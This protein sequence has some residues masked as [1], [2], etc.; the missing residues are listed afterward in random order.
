MA[1]FFPYAV[2]ARLAPFWLPFGVLVLT[3]LGTLRQDQAGTAPP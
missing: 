1:E 3:V 2:D